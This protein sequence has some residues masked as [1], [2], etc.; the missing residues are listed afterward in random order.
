MTV[1]CTGSVAN[2]RYS[3][4]RVYELGVNGNRNFYTP[5]AAFTAVVTDIH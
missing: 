1:E 2:G 5:Y 4:N 3:I